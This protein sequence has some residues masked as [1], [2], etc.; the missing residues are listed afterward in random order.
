MKQIFKNI[1]Y[2]TTFTIVTYFFL[3]VAASGV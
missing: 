2:I 1:I 3:Y